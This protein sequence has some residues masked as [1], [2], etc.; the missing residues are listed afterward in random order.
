LARAGLHIIL[1]DPTS[2]LHFEHVQ[3]LR[4]VLHAL[5]EQGNKVVVIERCRE[6]IKTAGWILGLAPGGQQGDRG[7]SHPEQGESPRLYQRVSPA[8][9]L[10]NG[11]DLAKVRQARDCVSA[12]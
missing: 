6:V 8:A 9:P 3:K 2:G 11:L 12:E 4:E 1:D 5:V 10:R 7:R